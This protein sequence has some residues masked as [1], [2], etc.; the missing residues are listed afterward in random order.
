MQNRALNF[1]Q[2]HRMRELIDRMLL[3]FADKTPEELARSFMS[4]AKNGD[5][6]ISGRFL[7]DLASASEKVQMLSYHALGDT[8]PERKDRGPGDSESSAAVLHAS[9]IA[10][11]NSPLSQGI[12]ANELVRKATQAIADQSERN[13]SE[14]VEIDATTSG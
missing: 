5:V 10:A 11:L 8:A 3:H 4:I 1:A 6:R 7:A 12:P 14:P 2:A 9:I 13:P